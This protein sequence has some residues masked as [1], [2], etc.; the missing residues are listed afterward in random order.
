M[1]PGG[2]GGG[3]SKNRSQTR[4]FA[5]DPL[6]HRFEEIRFLFRV[7]AAG[8]VGLVL[9]QFALLEEQDAV[10]DIIDGGQVVAGDED[11]RAQVAVHF[12]NLPE[13]AAV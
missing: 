9:D 4:I 6:F 11:G 2:G 1:R 5:G 3:R 7:H 8:N 12:P 13:N 10:A